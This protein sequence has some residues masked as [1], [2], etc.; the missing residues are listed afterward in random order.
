[1]KTNPSIHRVIRT[2]TIVLSLMLALAVILEFVASEALVVRVGQ[3]SA[4]C[5][6]QPPVPNLSLGDVLGCIR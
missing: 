3:V 2:R 1:M 4:N 5:A 6:N